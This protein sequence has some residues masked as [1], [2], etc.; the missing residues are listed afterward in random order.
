MSFPRPF[1]WLDRL[2]ALLAR[3]LAPNSRKIRTAC[4][5]AAIGTIGGGLVAACHVYNELGLYLA[6]ALVL[7]DQ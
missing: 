4:R 7:R 6:W 2:E 3:E 1:G 5:M